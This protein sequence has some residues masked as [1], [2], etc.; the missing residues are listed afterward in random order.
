[1][2]R[3]AWIAAIAA[4]LFSAASLAQWG[5]GA[6]GYGPGMGGMGGMGSGAYGACEQGGALEFLGLTA[7]QRSRI[8]AIMD[9][10][11]T[12]RLALMDGMHDLRSQAMR[13]GTPDYAA[14]ASL[15]DQ[16]FTVARDRR[17]RIDAV[18]TPEQRDRLH[19]GW[20][21]GRGFGPGR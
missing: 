2:R 9:E 12:Q 8:A 7:D 4:G 1:M 5:P 14:M 6:G 21:M 11:A 3:N 16:M 17:D 13:S 19:S 10:S 20:G 15:R 18:L